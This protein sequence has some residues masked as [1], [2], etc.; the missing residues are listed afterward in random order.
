MTAQTRAV[1]KSYF[2][3][4]LR[5]TQDQYGNLIDSFALIS[6]S[7]D[8]VQRTGDTMT[9]ALVLFANPSAAAPDL[10]AA[11]KRYVDAA[12]ASAAVV[13]SAAGSNGQVQYN[14][15]GAFGGFTVSGD[16]AS[17]STAGVLTLANTAVSAGTYIQPLVTIDS[18]GRITS[19][20]A[21]GYAQFQ[22]QKA[23]GTDGGAFTSGS[24]ATRTI[25][26]TV[27]NGITS[28]S[29]SSNQI[30][31]PAGTYYVRAKCAATKVNRHVARFRNVTDSTTAI[32]SMSHEADA[33]IGNNDYALVEGQF[34]IAGTKVYELQ[35]QCQTT[36]ATD[37]LGD[38]ANLGVAEVYSDVQIWKIA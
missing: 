6:T 34:T 21:T 37:G 8:Y 30:S 2:Q 32:A 16:A 11:T 36:N 22:D 4:G 13:T 1:L 31:L 35:H 10:Q 20:T 3:R 5:P 15:N 28:A 25:N 9:G 18:K 12:I 7:G 38:A 23:A 24:F 27:V 29:L 33:S 17:L 14:N 26:T 19:A